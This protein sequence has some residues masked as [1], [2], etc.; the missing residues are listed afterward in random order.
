MFMVIVVL[1]YIGL[2]RLYRFFYIFKRL[3][4]SVGYKEITVLIFNVYYSVREEREL[5]S[6]KYLVNL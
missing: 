5:Y 2:Q 4:N 6:I 3:E 1:I